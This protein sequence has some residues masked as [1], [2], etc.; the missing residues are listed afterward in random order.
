MVALDAFLAGDV[1]IDFPY[2]NAKFR[3]EKKTG[4]VY[5]RFYGE[6]E[7]GISPSSALYNDAI[8]AGKLIS[9]EEYFR[10]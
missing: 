5:R 10:D 3:Y 2:E 4:K 8:S 7:A 1:Y 9:R 6:A